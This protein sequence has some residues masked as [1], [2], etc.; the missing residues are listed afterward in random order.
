MR[1]PPDLADDT[2]VRALHAGFGVQAAELVLLP[3]GNDA[4]SWAYRV[5]VA[6]GPAYF[7][8]IR[9]GANPTRGASVPHHLHRHGVPHVPAPLM[10]SAGVPY[11]PLD[12]FALALYP[13][14]DPVSAPTAPPPRTTRW[15]RSWPGYG[16][17]ARTSSVRSGAAGRHR[18]LLPGL[19]PGEHRSTPARLAPLRLGG[20][21]HRRLRGAG[22]AGAGTGRGEP[23]CGRGR[24]HG[25]VRARRH[26]RRG[27]SV[28][29]HGHPPARARMT[30]P[31]DQRR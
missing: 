1:E 4:D 2:I 27:A 14:L 10:T 6:Q 16:G 21:G 30:A 18:P 8:K 24:L 20:P 17:P 26:R 15:R 25:P 23:A 12:R 28:G 7:L 3:V 29:H 5:Q 19:R 13:M 11:V 31:A 9:A 22:P